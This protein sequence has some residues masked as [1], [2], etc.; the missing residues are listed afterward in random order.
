MC[1]SPAVSDYPLRHGQGV[2]GVHNAQQRP[3]S[4]VGDAGLCVEGRVVEDGHTCGLRPGARGG[5]H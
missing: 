4:P 1:G 5:G 2:Q 3:Q